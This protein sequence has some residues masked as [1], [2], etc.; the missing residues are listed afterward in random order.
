MKEAALT[1]WF[2]N[3]LIG[4]YV[5]VIAVLVALLIHNFSALK[6]R[7]VY[8]RILSAGPGEVPEAPGVWPQEAPLGSDSLT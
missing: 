7:A 5:A 6:F 1:R 2:V 8:A 4:L 3:G